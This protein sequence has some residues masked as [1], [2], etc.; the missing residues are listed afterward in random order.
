MF[1]FGLRPRTVL[2]VQIGENFLVGVI[3]TGIGVAIGYPMLHQFMAA[4]M[5]NM[6]ENFGLVVAV[7]PLTVVVIVLVT[8]GVVTL[9]PCRLFW[10]LD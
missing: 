6:L 4:R 5:E 1:A 3:G 7:A 2:W 10:L 8:A 9:M